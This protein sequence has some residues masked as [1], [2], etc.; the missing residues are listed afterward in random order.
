MMLSGNRII[1]DEEVHISPL[2]RGYYFGDGIYEVFCIYDGALFEK[3][4]HFRRLLRSA[5][6]VRITL[7]YP[8]QRL[9]ELL[10]ELIAANRME[11]GL[12]YVQ[13]TR[14]AAPR[15]HPF[16]LNAEAIVTGWCT[17]YKRPLAQLENGIAAVLLEDI[18]WH[19]CDIK[20]LNLLPN[21]LLKQEAIDRG[22]DDAIFHRGDTVTESSSSNVMMVKD[23][24]LWTHPADNHILHGITRAVTLELAARLQIP[25]KEQF[26]TVDD[27]R[28]A[29]EI[30]L[31][32]T[33]AEITPVVK[34]DGR[35][36][37]AGVPGPIIRRLQQAYEA[38]LPGGSSL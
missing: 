15:S 27:L 33:G 37:G 34:L 35:P 26:Y 12:V 10:G 21:V 36:V 23:G 22:A 14:C 24:V 31:T 2:D 32:S 8:A 9:E 5:S 18:R 25:V 6:E 13:I 4:A 38:R 29:D 3:E 19:R 30:F 7:P 16:P 17:E 11:S 20:T 28:A 1:P